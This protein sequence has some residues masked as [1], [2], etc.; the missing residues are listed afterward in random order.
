[1][2]SSSFILTVCLAAAAFAMEDMSGGLC[3]DS[4]TLVPICVAGSNMEAKLQASESICFSETTGTGTAAGRA[5]KGKKCPTFEE[6]EAE[7]EEE[8]GSEACMLMSWGWIDEQGNENNA[9][10]DADIMSL[11]PEISSQIS[12]EAIEA[13]VNEYFESMFKGKKGRKMKKC[14]NKMDEQE[15]SALEDSAMGIANFRCFQK[16]FN[17]ACSNYVQEMYVQPLLDS[18]SSGFTSTG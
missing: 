11:V 13:C 16:V 6:I 14:F 3:L 18:F 8:F 9:T 17:N 1:M 12:E 4:E 10:I 2:P 15:Q 7:M 5:R